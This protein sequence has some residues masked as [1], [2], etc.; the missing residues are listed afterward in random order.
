M[1]L[2]PNTK[3]MTIKEVKQALKQVEHVE[4]ELAS[5]E[6]VPAH[7]HVTEVGEVAKRFIDCG[8]KLRDEKKAN[9]Q[10]WTAD[11]VEHRLSAEKLNSIIELSEKELLISEHLPVEVEYQSNTIGKYNLAF[12]NGK[13][14]LEST[15][16]DCLAKDKCGIPEEKLPRSKK[17]KMKLSEFQQMQCDPNAGCC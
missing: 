16:T 17:P 6:K 11:D 3:T 1:L 12:Q 5:G 7:F 9:F 15:L 8:G 2:I 13:F 14:I 10:L 4:F